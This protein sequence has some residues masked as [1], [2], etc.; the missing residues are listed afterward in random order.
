MFA[1]IVDDTY[2]AATNNG[3]DVTDVAVAV[4]TANAVVFVVADDVAVVAANAVDVVIS[5]VADMAAVVLFSFSLNFNFLDVLETLNVKIK[6]A[7]LLFSLNP[8]P[9]T[10]P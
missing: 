1:G 6:E 8:N 5:D 2:V 7:S 3:V 4:V 9:D 10:I